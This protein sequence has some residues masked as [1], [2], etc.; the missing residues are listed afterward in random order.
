VDNPRVTLK[1]IALALALCACKRGSASDPAPC[2]TVGNK[3]NAVAHA[4]LDAAKLD[5]ALRQKAE[6]QLGPLRDEVE[7]A[8]TDKAW[9][10]DVRKCLVAATTGVAMQTCAATLTPE[11]RGALPGANAP[12]QP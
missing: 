1:T 6:L 8:C 5:P 10:L 9:P 7:R 12:T 4:E 11:Q 2:A 3:V